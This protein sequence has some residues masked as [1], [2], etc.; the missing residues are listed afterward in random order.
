MTKEEIIEKL[1][2][3]SATEKNKKIEDD[4][5][6]PKNSLSAILKGTKV[7]S[8]KYINVCIEYL[9]PKI[10]EKV[11]EELPLV[12]NLEEKPKEVVIPAP[13]KIEVKKEEFKPEKVIELN[14]KSEINFSNLLNKFQRIINSESD[15]KTALSLLKEEVKNPELKLNGRQRES[16]IGRCDNF[17][18]G[19]YSLKN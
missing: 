13:E 18:N 16:I 4:L 14:G 6:L 9:E 2:N 3:L 12:P 10:A 17:I 11:V 15:K 5:G 19:K 7:L 8:D 1:K